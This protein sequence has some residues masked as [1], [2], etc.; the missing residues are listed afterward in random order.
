MRIV[1]T[2]RCY[3]CGQLGHIYVNC[4]YHALKNATT[5]EERAQAEREIQKARAAVKGQGWRGSV[6]RIETKIEKMMDEQ[7]NE[8]QNDIEQNNEQNDFEQNHS[9]QNISLVGQLNGT[10]GE[11]NIDTESSNS[12]NKNKKAQVNFGQDVCFRCGRA[13]H[14]SKECTFEDNRI[15]YI[16]GE[17]GHVAK[18]CPANQ[19]LREERKKMQQA[20]K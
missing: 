10:E 9:E 6:H 7:K 1:T 5:A 19:K 3:H 13:G 18:K 12:D 14:K 4:P 15:C 16:C 20:K 8:Q 17:F 11:L 2:E